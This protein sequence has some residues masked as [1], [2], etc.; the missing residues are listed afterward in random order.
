MI[1]FIQVVFAPPTTKS[2][3]PESKN[4]WQQVNIFNSSALKTITVGQELKC[5]LVAFELLWQTFTR[6]DKSLFMF[7]IDDMQVD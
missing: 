1:C 3:I 2:F 4:I 7:H 5:F 6:E